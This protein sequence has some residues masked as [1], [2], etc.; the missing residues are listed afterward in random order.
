MHQVAI[1]ELTPEEGRFPRFPRP[2]DPSS[3]LDVLLSCGSKKGACL[4]PSRLSGGRLAAVPARVPL[5]PHLNWVLIFS[6]A[7][8]VAVILIVV[9]I[10]VEVGDIVL[11][12]LPSNKIAI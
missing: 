6:V 3:F 2:I 4:C 1:R 12:I 9:I 7:V 5:Q 11:N 8:V 10:G